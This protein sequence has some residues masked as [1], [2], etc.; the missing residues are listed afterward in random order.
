MGSKKAWTI[1]PVPGRITINFITF[2]V[3]FAA[4][5]KQIEIATKIYR[6]KIRLPGRWP[7]LDWYG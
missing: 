4:V 7:R 1:K 3:I 5:I 2:I 6:V